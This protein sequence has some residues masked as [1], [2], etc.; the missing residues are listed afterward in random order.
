MGVRKVRRNAQMRERQ[1][2]H[3]SVENIISGVETWFYADGLWRIPIPGIGESQ[4]IAWG[5]VGNV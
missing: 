3:D 2:G 1:Q 5:K 4:P